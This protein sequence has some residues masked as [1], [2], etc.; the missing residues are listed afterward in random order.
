MKPN[1]SSGKA[2]LNPAAAGEGLVSWDISRLKLPSPLGRLGKLCYKTGP[3]PRQ[4]RSKEERGSWAEPPD[5]SL[6]TPE[7]ALMKTWVMSTSAMPGGRAHKDG[8]C[9][10]THAEALAKTLLL[11]K[12]A[13]GLYGATGQ[14]R[15]S[16]SPAHPSLTRRVSGPA[17]L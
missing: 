16:S 2:Q 12:T 1:G 14:N 11:R 8:T 5:P 10:N 15:K 7:P 9:T 13:S 3:G 17:K 4:K 6:V